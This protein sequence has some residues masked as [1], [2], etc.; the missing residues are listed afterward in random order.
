[1]ND[2]I[3]IGNIKE[4]F[5]LLLNYRKSMHEMKLACLIWWYLAEGGGIAVYRKRSFEGRGR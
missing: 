4:I 2:E 3:V 1:M 5:L